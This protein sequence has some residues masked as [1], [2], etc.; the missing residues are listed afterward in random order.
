M[1]QY[2][3]KSLAG[4]YVVDTSTTSGKEKNIEVDGEPFHVTMKSLSKN[5]LVVEVNG[6]TFE[7]EFLEEGKNMVKLGIGSEVFSFDLEVVG[8][9]G[10]RDQVQE[11]FTEIESIVPGKVVGVQVGVGDEVHPGDTLILIESMKMETAVSSS[12]HGKVVAVRVRK[13]DF[14]KR[15][16][17]LVRIANAPK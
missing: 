13:G 6:T 11:P 14:V 10:Q 12:T 15:G 3:L 1:T 9:E 17:G 7:T 4:T 2:R 16:Q 5:R 8:S